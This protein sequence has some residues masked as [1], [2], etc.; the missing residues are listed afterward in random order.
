M[1]G[2]AGHIVLR[3]VEVASG[4]IFETYVSMTVAYSSHVS[5]AYSLKKSLAI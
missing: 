4:A 3:R 1:A 2:E 5:D